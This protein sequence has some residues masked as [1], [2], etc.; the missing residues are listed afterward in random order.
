M[1]FF[2]DMSEEN[3]TITNKKHKYDEDVT[4]VDNYLDESNENNNI[5]EDY[6]DDANYIFEDDDSEYDDMDEEETDD[7]EDI[8]DIDEEQPEEESAP[9]KVASK[10][11][12]V[13][14]SETHS[15]TSSKKE[16]NNIQ[17]EKIT[18]ETII[19]KGTTIN[20]D[21][22][23]I[24]SLLIN[25]NVHGNVNVEGKLSLYG[26]VSGG[27]ISA[28]ELYLENTHVEGN[29]TCNGIAKIGNEA[30]VIGNITS[31]GAVITGAVM[32]D[33]DSKGSVILDASSIVKGNIKS[34]S[35]QINNGAV[36][37]GICSQC[38]AENNATT[39]F[40][41]YKKKNTKK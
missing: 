38:Y 21:I 1:G 11:R 26:T 6:S 33:I 10:K 30:V 25:G 28:T 29:I 24:G 5:Y 14:P 34:T 36:L 8:D 37:E 32:G 27:N 3:E 39:F 22:N 20:G 40:D 23:V 17:P 19:D 15:E 16:N 31:K 41:K 9:I 12:S 4:D 18:G 2:K 13:T 35:V 7:D